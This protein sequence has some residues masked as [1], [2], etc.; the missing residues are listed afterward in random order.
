MRSLIQADEEK[1]ELLIYIPFLVLLA[2][3]ML[4][5]LGGE[6]RRLEYEKMVIAHMKDGAKD[7]P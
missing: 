2:W 4:T 1:V 5:I 3:A 7:K 6:K